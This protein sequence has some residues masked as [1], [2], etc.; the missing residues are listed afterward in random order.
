MALGRF[1]KIPIYPISYLLEGEYF[2]KE[3]PLNRVRG[4]HRSITGFRVSGLEF[5]GQRRSVGLKV[6]L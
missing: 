6:F 2:S 4:I 5:R 1:N 3:F